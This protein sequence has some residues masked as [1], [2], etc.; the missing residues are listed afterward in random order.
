MNA[1]RKVLS[2]MLAAGLLAATGCQ[3]DDAVEKDV[4]NAAEDVQREG[5]KAG[6]E[7][8]EETKD[9]TNGRDDKD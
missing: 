2:I 9:A 7:I 8:D 6:K 4:N 1:T 3:S 5:E